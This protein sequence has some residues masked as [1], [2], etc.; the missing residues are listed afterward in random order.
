MN[1]RQLTLLLLVIAAFVGRNLY[2][3]SFLVNGDN[4]I[5]YHQELCPTVHQP[6]PSNQLN[7]TKQATPPKTVVIFTCNEFY[8]S[9]V[10]SSVVSVRIDGGYMGDIAVI[11]EE[12]S[13]VT[14]SW[15]K[16]QVKLEYDQRNKGMLEDRDD[17]FFVFS[18]DD[19]FHSLLQNPKISFLK[20]TPPKA[21]CLPPKRNRGHRGYYL[22]TLIYHPTIAEKWDIVLCTYPCEDLIA[23][24]YLP[25]CLPSL[26]S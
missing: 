1:A 24:L 26:F 17:K 2:Y 18:S 4:T 25:A 14:M 19:L 11:L 23:F 22:K 10:A 16:D 3:H 5:S 9:A 6:Q 7:V 15:M 21:P 20:Q 8:A 12:S 13:N